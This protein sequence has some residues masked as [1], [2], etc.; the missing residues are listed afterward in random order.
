MTLA[1]KLAKTTGAHVL[2]VFGERL[3]Y[4]QG[5]V[6]H[7]RPIAEGGID[8]PSLLNSEIERTILQCPSLYLWGYDRF[9]A[10]D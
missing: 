3:S 5:Y 9:K 6:I 8:T 2:M 7:V 4:G 10:R 1:S